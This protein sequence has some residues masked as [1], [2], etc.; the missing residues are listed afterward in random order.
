MAS[1]FSKPPGKSQP[2]G[3]WSPTVR[4]IITV[5]LIMHF[6]C[7][8]VVLSSNNGRSPLQNRLVRIFGF[9]TQLLNFD[10][11]FAPFA[12]TNGEQTDDV[13]FVIDLYAD[14][15]KSVDQQPLL[16]TVTLPDHGSKLLDSQKRY[17]N[18]GR[19]IAFYSDPLNPQD[20]VTG[21][22]ARAVGKR[23]MDENDAKRCVIRCL[24]RASQPM[25]IEQVLPGFP[26]D[27]PTD[28]R[29]DIPIYE[30]DVWIDE[31][32]QVQLIKRVSAA[33]A[34]TRQAAPRQ[35]GS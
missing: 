28:P 3:P 29:Y 33:E 13:A 34:A 8:F 26:R 10:P 16:K 11:N 7:V 31:D 21:A 25:D 35:G 23:I 15:E 24:R 22:I 19:T 1:S 14:G 4:S 32:N 6:T 17:F 30:A 20:D 12:L 27:N 18:L 5:L 2:A 9:Y